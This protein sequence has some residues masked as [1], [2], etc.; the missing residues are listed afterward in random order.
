MSIFDIQYIVDPAAAVVARLVVD[1]DVSRLAAVGD[2]PTRCAELSDMVA[3][4]QRGISSIHMTVLPYSAKLQLR[5]DFLAAARLLSGKGGLIVRLSEAR[6]APALRRELAARFARVEARG[7]LQFLCREPIDEADPPSEVE[8]Q[9]IQHLDPASG[10]TLTFQ[11]SPGLFS[12]GEVD[13]GTRLLLDA[14]AEAFADLAGSRV[15]DVGCGYG[16]VGCVLAARGAHTTMVDSDWRAVKLARANLAANL[17]RG[18]ALV[19]DATRA[20][21]AGPFD[22]IV[23]NPP[24]HAGSAR[25]RRLFDLAA[26]E[27]AHVLIVVRATLNYEKWLE[28]DYCVERVAEREGYKVIAFGRRG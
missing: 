15:L 28:S 6:V 19:G 17:L 8:G 14:G 1:Y 16:A 21:P 20:L 9:A 18:E 27:S 13:P 12:H 23:S 25:L 22:L 26:K 24:T 4:G 5:R 10:R 2:T 3:E 11:T 7:A